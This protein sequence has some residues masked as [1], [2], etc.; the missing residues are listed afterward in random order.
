MA[1]MDSFSLVYGISN[2][3]YQ[4]N[5]ISDTMPIANA[6]ALCTGKITFQVFV[7]NFY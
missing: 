6:L 7:N 5:D 3:T 2:Y 4:V 1:K